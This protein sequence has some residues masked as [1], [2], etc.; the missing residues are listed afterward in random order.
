[1]DY[2][3]SSVDRALRMLQALS[4]LPGS[5]VTELA[6]RTGCTKSQTFRILYTLE[7]QGYVTKDADRSYR[8]GFQ[9]M[10][11]GDQARRQSPLIA[12]AEPHI[13]DI[14]ERIRQNV[15]LIVRHGMRTACV[16]LR[17]SPDRDQIYAEFG[18]TGPLHA[19]GGPK[20][21]LANAPC[22]IQEAVL[23]G[24]LTRYTR[25]TI[26]DPDTLRALLEKIRTD[27]WH[28]S[29]ADL[30]DDKRSVAAPVRDASGEVV[31]AISVTAPEDYLQ[32]ARLD[33]TR[34]L[35]LQTVERLSVA[36]GYRGTPVVH[37]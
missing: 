17:A 16:L 7:A 11:L 23:T 35:V 21:M 5:G 20:V 9:T 14:Y 22:E 26:C 13:N 12:A 18:R 24:E 36:L 29:E 15:L 10:L 33:E 34:D 6:E 25:K 4:E 30:D 31:A 19:G 2:T 27:G 37:A 3:I 32:G 28:L 8:L 1:M